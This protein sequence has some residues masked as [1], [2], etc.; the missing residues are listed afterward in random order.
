MIRPISLG[1]RVQ[2]LLF[3]QWL[4][5]CASPAHAE[6]V[7]ST[8][9][10]TAPNQIAIPVSPSSSSSTQDAIDGSVGDSTSRAQASTQISVQASVNVGVGILLSRYQLATGTEVYH[11]I[12]L[13]WGKYFDPA[14]NA[15]VYTYGM[16]FGFSPLVDAK[17]VVN[18]P[19]V[20][21]DLE[22]L[23]QAGVEGVRWF[24]TPDGRNLIFDAN[25]VP[26]GRGQGFRDDLWAALDLLDARQ[27]G[28]LLVLID[29][30]TWFKPEG[31]FQG[32]LFGHAQVILNQAKRQAFY[33]TV[34]IPILDDITAWQAARPGKSLPVAAIDLGNELEFGTNDRQAT[35]ASI[36][37]MQTYV[38][39]AAV[40]VH[41]HLP[42][43][44]VT[45]GARDA[46]SL[47]DYWTD[48]ALGVLPGQGLDFYSFHH[49]GPDPLDGPG[50]LRERLRLDQLDK[51]VYL[52]EF[53]GKNAPLGAP[54]VYLAPI[55]GTRHGRAIK[56]WLS[57]SYLWSLNGA[58]QF[59]PDNPLMTSQEIT[60]L[61]TDAFAAPDLLINSIRVPP[62]IVE[63]S[64]VVFFVTV[65]NQGGR[66][67]EVNRLELR[68][69]GRPLGSTT[70]PPLA[71]GEQMI[72]TLPQEPWVAT[73]G[74][75]SLTVTVDAL[76]EIDEVNEANN[77]SMT[78][79]SV[80][81]RP[82]LQITDVSTPR[83]MME[84]DDVQFTATI[85]NTG[86]ASSSAS[87]VRVQI[88]DMLLGSGTV[89]ELAVGETVKI[90]LPPTPWKAVQ[91]THALRLEVDPEHQVQESHEENNAFT[92]MLTVSGVPEAQTHAVSGKVVSTD[93]FPIERAQVVLKGCRLVKRRVV[94]ASDGSF[95]FDGLSDDS[96]WLIVRRSGYR[97]ALQRVTVEGQDVTGIEVV[98]EPFR[99]RVWFGSEV[100]DR[101]A[102]G[103]L[104]A[105]EALGIM[106]PEV[107]Q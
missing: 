43:V 103:L 21:Q 14:R 72:F 67:A 76:L 16:D 91:G 51:R 20:T 31:T 90:L 79:F 74:M 93:G 46:Q 105:A 18:N 102:T 33:E 83:T 57:G 88:D 27:M 96:Y 19:Q 63:G 60:K 97:P 11:F 23:H 17:R 7:S 85:T 64:S 94:T 2:L 56:G 107:A 29:G 41:Q 52:E 38:R 42:G 73:A 8:V 50:G 106:T 1:S 32:A 5:I 62:S 40:L 55:G 78:Q 68:L 66:R 34:L 25:R 70:V 104:Q 44:P 59:S 92:M 35:G 89:P 84:G 36:T 48:Q 61:L 81:G 80:I 10:A 39:E 86:T 69:D 54:Q 28:V 15:F 53:P 4:V 37:D 95:R 49:Y 45:V 101:L 9:S 77:V 98:L 82:D 58:D 6:E 12:N 30:N 100:S 87:Q 13:P 24:V 3:G 22:S 71:G 99:M 65:A 47:V 75:H 26:T